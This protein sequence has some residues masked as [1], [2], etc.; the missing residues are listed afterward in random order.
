MNTKE[1]LRDQA[2]GTITIP[3]YYDWELGEEIKG[4]L[5]LHS[6]LYTYRTELGVVSGWTMS[7][8]CTID[9]PVKDVWPY[10]K[11]FNLWQKKH[12]YSGVVGDLEGQIF[13][14]G[15][16]SVAVAGS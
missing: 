9:R 4:D 10:F 12:Y 6:R 11:D 5:C 1:N 3:K 7:I 8:T 2:G 15:D 16:D 14:L 13:S